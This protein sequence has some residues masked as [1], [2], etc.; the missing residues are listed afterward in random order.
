MKS[1]TSGRCHAAAAA[2]LLVFSPGVLTA[3]RVVVRP[4]DTGEALRNPA[5]GWVLHYYDNALSHYGNREAPH[6]T[7]DDFPGLTVVYLRLAWGFLEPEKG[8]FNWSVVDGPAQRFIDRGL[9]VAFRFSCYEGHSKQFDA[10]PPW[11]R[12]AGAQGAMTTERPGEEYW[13]PR[14]DDP[15]FLQ[16]LDEFLA[17]AGRRYDGNP[18][19]AWI[20]VGSFGIWGEGHTKLDYTRETRRRHVELHAR[21]F[22]RTLIAVNDDLGGQWGKLG[23]LDDLVVGPGRFTLRDDSILVN[24]GVRA[25]RSAFMAQRFWPH[26]PIIL[27]SEHYGAPRGKGYWNDGAIYAE[28]VEAYR[29]SYVSIHWFPREFLQG[30]LDFVRRMNQRIGYRLRLREASWPATVVRRGRF[31]LVT[32]WQNVGVAPCYPGGHVALTL[33]TD[34]GGIVAVFVDE[35]WNLRDVGVDVPGPDSRIVEYHDAGPRIDGRDSIRKMPLPSIAIPQG[36]LNRAALP[37]KRRS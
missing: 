11:L 16:H 27:E 34:R 13:Q 36:P 21:H 18:N 14:F 22:P 12:A 37:S 30:N 5:M 26:E 29:G 1:P 25:Y 8:R 24:P 6:D 9:Q 32:Q 10:A 7:L 2:L 35:S 20:D 23:T 19:V 15:I 3:D 33:K 28:A 4:A 17:A 31:D